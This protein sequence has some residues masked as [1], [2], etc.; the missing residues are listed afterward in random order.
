MRQDTR[1]FTESNNCNGTL[2]PGFSCT[3]DVVFKPTA[4]GALS[5]KI[6]IED[7]AQKGLQSIPLF[8][9]GD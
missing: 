9:I 1:D 8:G 7:N 3:I 2:K 5:A 6:V 4:K